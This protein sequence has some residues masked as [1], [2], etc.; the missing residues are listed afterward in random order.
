[1][2][3]VPKT[4]PDSHF[5]SWIE[6]LDSSVLD[7]YPQYSGMTVL[8]AFYTDADSILFDPSKGFVE[9]NDNEIV[10]E[11]AESYNNI[12]ETEKIAGTGTINIT[13]GSMTITGTNTQFLSQCQI[14]CHLIISNEKI[15]GVVKSVESDTSLT[16]YKFLNYNI[17]DIKFRIGKSVSLSQYLHVRYITENS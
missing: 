11:S 5:I 3:T 12:I 7:N 4:E 13:A 2:Y 10:Y 1:M 17:K 8:D 16:V 14:G 9:M 15:S 6:S